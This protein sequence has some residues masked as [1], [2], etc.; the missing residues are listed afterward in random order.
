MTDVVCLPLSVSGVIPYSVLFLCYCSE[1]EGYFF[2]QAGGSTQPGN[3][4][5]FSIMHQTFKSLYPAKQD[6]KYFVW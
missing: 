3:T 4:R 1:A 6:S 2:D 5:D